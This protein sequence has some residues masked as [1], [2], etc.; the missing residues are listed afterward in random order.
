MPP[1]TMSTGM[2]SSPAVWCAGICMCPLMNMNMIGAMVLMPSFHPGEGK[3]TAD[4]I[5][6]GRTMVKGSPEPASTCSPRLLVYV[7]VLV[8]PQNFARSMPTRS[9]SADSHF[10]RTF[11]TSAAKIA[12]VVGSFFASRL[13]FASRSYCATRLASSACFVTLAASASPSEI[14]RCGSHGASGMSL[15]YGKGSSLGS[16]SST[17]PVR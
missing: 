16:T 9:P 7:Y 10:S 3:A 17:R 2:M 13:A 11:F 8:Q 14:S 15:K 4:S 5:T 12:P 6:A 1:E